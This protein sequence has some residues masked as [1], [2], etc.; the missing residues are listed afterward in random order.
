MIEKQIQELS[1]LTGPDYAARRNAF[2]DQA[3]TQYNPAP[4]IKELEDAINIS[5]NMTAPYFELAGQY[6]G[7]NRLED[8]IASYEKVLTIQPRNAKALLV[9]LNQQKHLRV[10]AV[11]LGIEA[12]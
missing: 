5:P 1:L 7:A 11:A 9:V 10:L 6:K 3:L 4:A 8:A 12:G 2:L